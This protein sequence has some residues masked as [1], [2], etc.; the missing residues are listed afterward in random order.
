MHHQAKN[1][2]H[3]GTSVVQLNS[4]LLKL[5]LLVEL[6]PSALEG[7]VTKISGELVSESWHILHD[8]NFKQTDER[9]DLNEA[10][11]GDGI[12]SEDGGK[13]V[14]VGVEGV[15]V[16]INISAE[17]S[18]RACDDVSQESKLSDTAV[19]DLNVSEAVESLLVGTI[20]QAEG[21]EEADRGLGAKLTLEVVEGGGGLADL[22]GGKGG[23]RGDGGGEDDGLHGCIVGVGELEM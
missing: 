11:G 3:S 13:T 23:S 22:G 8:G 6:V 20:E 9:E 14:G 15:A 4:T 12:R 18:T 1:S 21:V 19:L 17:V 5:G 16:E 2:H 7:S 10:L